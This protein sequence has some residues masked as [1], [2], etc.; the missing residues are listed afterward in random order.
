M[1]LEERFVFIVTV[2][3]Y[4]GRR[5]VCREGNFRLGSEMRVVMLFIFLFRGSFCRLVKED[6]GIIKFMRI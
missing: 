3:G 1:W 5:E 2:W 6:L 4:S